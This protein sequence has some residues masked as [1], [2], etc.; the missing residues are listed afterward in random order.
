MCCGDTFYYMRLG[1]CV[2]VGSF[3]GNS[4]GLREDLE[5]LGEGSP[6]VGA[7][8]PDTLHGVQRSGP[9]GALQTHYGLSLGT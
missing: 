5:S 8:G 3:P 4:G 7:W 6:A 2:S 1:S 9:M